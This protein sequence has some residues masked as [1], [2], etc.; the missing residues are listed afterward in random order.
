MKRKCLSLF[1]L[2]ALCLSLSV[3]VFA[4]APGDFVVDDANLLTDAEEYRLAE[5]LQSI[6]QTYNAQV[7]VVT[8]PSSGGVNVDYLVEDIYDGTGY[9]YGPGHDGI[10]LM[11][12]MSPREY[13]ILSNGFAADA[14]TMSRIDAIGEYIVSDLS[15]GDYDDA[16]HGFADRCDYYLNGHLNGFPFRFG[17]NLAIA[18]AIGLLAGLI[19][20]LVLKGQLKSVRQQ[21]QADVYMKSGSMNITASHDLF[22][23]RNVHRTKKETSSSS[24]SGGGGSRNVGGGSF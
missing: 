8:V 12:C 22:L 2:L 24:R 15:D 9:G 5:K 7:V 18:L 19:T 13:R 23:Y 21:H 10:L 16:F 17:L 6:S 11:V 20:A 3:T 14:I 4:A 1:L